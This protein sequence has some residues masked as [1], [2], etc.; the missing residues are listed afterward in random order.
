MSR[1]PH[2][3]RSG[4]IPRP[5]TPLIGR[6]T[7][8][9]A[10]CDLL[11]RPDTRLVTLI[12][13]GGIGKTRLALAVAERLRGEWRDGVVY[14]GLQS[15]SDYEHV[16]SAIAQAFGVRESGDESIADGLWAALEPQQ[17]LLVLDNFEQVLPAATLIGETLERCPQVRFLITSRAMLHLYGEYDVPIPTLELPD[18]QHLP[19]VESLSKSE[20]IRLFVERS[21]AV[22]P[23]FTLSERNGPVVAA[24]CARVD[25][26]PLAIELA[27]ARTRLLSPPDLLSRLERRMPVLTGGPRNQPSRQQTMRDT[28]AWSYDLLPAEEQRLFRQLA[29]FAGGWT[30]EAAEVVCGHDENVLDSLT[31]LVDHSLVRWD[32][33]ANGS[34]RFGLLETIREFGLGQLEALG[35]SVSVRD[36]HARWCSAL[37]HEAVTHYSS[38]TEP[39]WHRRL[40]L[41]LHNLRAALMWLLK[42]GEAEPGLRLVAD[43]GSF[44]FAGGYLSEGM[45]QADAFLAMPS[46]EPRSS[47]RGRALNAAGFLAVWAGDF[48]RAYDYAVEAVAILEERENLAG[49]PAAL[50]TRGIVARYQGDV[51]AA[52]TYTNRSVALAREV[53]DTLVLTRALS[54]VAAIEY[55]PGDKESRQRAEVALQEGLQVARESGNPSNAA[56][57]LIRLARF[58]QHANEFDQ[59]AEQ[60]REAIA[61]YHQAGYVS[62]IPESLEGLAVVVAWQGY[63]PLAT[64]M[65]GAAAALRSRIR[66][67]VQA[68]LQLDNEPAIAAARAALGEEAFASYWQSGSALTMEDAVAEALASP[69]PLTASEQAEISTTPGHPLTTRELEVVKGLVDGLS[70]AEIASVLFI[71]PN[72]VSNHVSNIMNK[73][74]LDSRTAI[75]TWAVRHGVG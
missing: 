69:E 55:Q 4:R 59:A 11:R 5:L 17:L 35:E 23:A 70:N 25:N 63:A 38:H 49:L 60:Y 16:A 53:G 66:A 74:G 15:I 33:Q 45:A 65:F 50:L 34:T 37:A 62:M 9:D 71:S 68:I 13:P 57:I 22:S 2:D 20:A 75:A 18:L 6:E 3:D 21:Q 8:L 67:P 19:D 36:R 7:V 44:W 30:L 26:L 10:I 48:E 41:E 31:T 56:L 29:V 46:A 73:L 52:K 12:G 39:E 47:A 14:V 28:I 51:D 43:L 27:A 1:V 64:R 24:I 58:A 61:L 40:D 72:T 54:I 42:Q 32:E